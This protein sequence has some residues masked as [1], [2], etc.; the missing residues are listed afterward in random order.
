MTKLN[1]TA[2]EVLTTTRSVRKRLD[3][4]REVSTD[5]IMECLEIALQ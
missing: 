4:D 5:V 2:D 3:F 1:L